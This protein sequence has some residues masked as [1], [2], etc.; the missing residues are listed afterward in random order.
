VLGILT[1]VELLAEFFDDLFWNLTFINSE[2]LNVLSTIKLDLENTKRLLFFRNL[3]IPP[4][5]VR[6]TPL[7]SLRHLATGSGVDTRGIRSQVSTSISPH[8][9]RLS[10]ILRSVL[11]ISGYALRSLMLLWLVPERL[12]PVA[13]RVLNLIIFL[14]GL[15]ARLFAIGISN[16]LVWVDWSTGFYL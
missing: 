9:L 8:F 12:G 5:G 1:N 11:S 2:K 14:L 6:S 3:V 4:F 10:V 13:K 16:I 7:I 15:V